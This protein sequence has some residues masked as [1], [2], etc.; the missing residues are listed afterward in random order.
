MRSATGHTNGTWVPKK[1]YAG[2]L[3]AYAPSPSTRLSKAD[4]NSLHILELVALQVVSATIRTLPNQASTRRS[5]RI[6][7][8]HVRARHAAPHVR[9]ITAS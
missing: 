1:K 5:H 9:T 8:E 2:T 7:R 4:R 6:A 3:Q